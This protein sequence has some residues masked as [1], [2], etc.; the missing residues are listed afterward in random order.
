VNSPVD[1]EES[2]FRLI[3]PNEMVPAACCRRGSHPGD[4]AY[5]PQEECLMG[6]MLFRNNKVLV[7]VLDYFKNTTKNPLIIFIDPF[8][9]ENGNKHFAPGAGPPEQGT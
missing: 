3:N 5:I 6:N 8:N 1:F 7:L 9:K 2:L 4:S